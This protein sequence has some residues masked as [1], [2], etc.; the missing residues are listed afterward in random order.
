MDDLEM[1]REYSGYLIKWNDFYAHFTIVKDGIEIKQSVG[2]LKACK[3]WI[4]KKNKQRFE[5]IP[6]LHKFRYSSER[7]LGEA[8]SIVDNEYVWVVSGKERSKEQIS[9]MWLDTPKN[10]Q[11]LID[12]EIKNKQIANLREEIEFIEDSTERLTAEMMVDQG[13]KGEEGV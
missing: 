5:R 6:I 1:E 9:N 7:T 10:R 3:E 8:T 13:N 12:I 4:D 11:A 2:T